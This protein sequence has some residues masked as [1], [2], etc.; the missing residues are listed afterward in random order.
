MHEI[1]DNPAIRDVYAR[2]RTTLANERTLLSYLRTFI[3][4]AA[5]GA[6]S[7]HFLPGCKAIGIACCSLSIASLVVGLYRFLSVRALMNKV[8]DVPDSFGGV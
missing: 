7:F 3:G 1:R 5:A 6:T 4:L 8:E 2:I